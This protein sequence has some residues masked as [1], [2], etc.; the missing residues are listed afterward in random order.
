M[1]TRVYMGLDLTMCV[2]KASL[3]HVA[4]GLPFKF[5]VIVMVVFIAIIVLMIVMASSQYYYCSHFSGVCVTQ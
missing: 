3:Q 2:F 4:T 1:N 5:V